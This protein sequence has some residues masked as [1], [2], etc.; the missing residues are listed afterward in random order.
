VSKVA[1]RRFFTF[2]PRLST[3]N[4]SH[5][6]PRRPAARDSSARQPDSFFRQSAKG[7]HYSFPGA[8]APG[9]IPGLFRRRTG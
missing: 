7:G 4:C 2:N 8:V 1:S 5:E 9:H 3:F 6:I